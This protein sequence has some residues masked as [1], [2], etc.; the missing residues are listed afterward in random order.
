MFMVHLFGFKGC[1]KKN[2]DENISLSADVLKG[3]D[4]RLSALHFI[5]EQDCGTTSAESWINNVLNKKK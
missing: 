3:I 2:I 1:T 5:L 4:S